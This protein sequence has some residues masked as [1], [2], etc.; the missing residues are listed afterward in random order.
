MAKQA[1][2]KL[3]LLYLIQIFEE[4]T[5]ENH[6]ITMSEI[7]QKLQ[8][9]MRLDNK[10]DRKSVYDDIDQLQDFGYDII[11]EQTK[12][13]TYYKLASRDFEIFELKKVV[14]EVISQI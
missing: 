6:G 1:G 7:R 13:D 3:K 8:D 12:T 10:P 4:C 5:D 11:Q 2:Q 9:L 14:T